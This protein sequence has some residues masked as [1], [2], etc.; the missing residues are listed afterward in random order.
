MRDV[1]RGAA[2]WLAGNG[3]ERRD[4]VLGEDVKGG[5]VAGG[6]RGRGGGGGRTDGAGACGGDGGGN[7]GADG[8]EIELEAHW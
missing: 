2:S 8:E 5:V 1:P 6:G 4:E 7:V 3:L